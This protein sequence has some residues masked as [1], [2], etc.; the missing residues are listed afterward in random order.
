MEN[1]IPIKESQHCLWRMALVILHVPA[2]A[3]CMAIN[4]MA[5]PAFTEPGKLLDPTGN[6]F[7]L[8]YL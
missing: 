2:F 6:E 1:Q 8:P 4:Y 3:A 7:N 5:T